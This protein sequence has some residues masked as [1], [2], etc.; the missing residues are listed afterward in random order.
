MEFK[1]VIELKDKLKHL[2]KDKKVS[3][4]LLY[5][6]SETYSDFDNFRK[7][8]E[9]GEIKVHRIWMLLYYLKRFGE[10]YEEAALEL[11]EIEN[12]YR[13][14]VWTNIIWYDKKIKNKPE[15]IPVGVRWAEL[16]T[17]GGEK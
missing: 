15:I 11:K 14:V 1:R 9:K 3:K 4:A 8:L 2:L 12:I 5:R 16:L 13:D 7:E 6:I 17:R 10:R